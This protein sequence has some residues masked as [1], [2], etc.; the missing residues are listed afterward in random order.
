[1]PH[2]FTQQLLLWAAQHPRP[3]PWKGERD[4]YKIWLS[5]VILQQTRVEQGLPYYERFVAQYP[6]IR[7]L[8]DASEDELFKLWEGLGYYSRARNLHATAKHIAYDLNGLFPSTYEGIR[9]L[10]GVGDYTAAAIASFA[11]DLPHAVLDGNVYRVL[12][13]FFGIE[14]PTDTP[15]AKRTFAAIAQEL[16]DLEQPAAFNQAIM[17]FGATWCTPR[18]PQCGDCPMRSACKALQMGKV[19]ELPFKSKK[20]SKKERFFCY[21]LVQYQGSTFVRKREDRDIWKGLWEFPLREADSMTAL[22]SWDEEALKIWLHEQ[23]FSSQNP[24]EWHLK[25][26]SKIRQQT[27]THRIVTAI[28]CEVYLPEHW[29]SNEV[30]HVIFKHFSS[31]SWDFLKQNVAFPRII[32]AHLGDSSMTLF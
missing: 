12:A 29:S 6:S 11:F 19:L 25:L 22:T 26:H 2:F 20:I 5:E 4:P 13:R 24:A 9:A 28:F 18:Q 17:D 27:L 32:D 3:L 14:M 31:F 21:F 15:T 23:F 7:E 1:M 30:Q 10:K 16:L 8:A